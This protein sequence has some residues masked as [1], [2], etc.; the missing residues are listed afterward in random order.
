[1]NSLKRFYIALLLT[2]LSVAWRFA[3]FFTLD[4]E[5][6][7][8]KV[9]LGLMGLLFLGIG[10]HT[11]MRLRK[12]DSWFLFLYCW[13]MSWHWGGLPVIEEHNASMTLSLYLLGSIL[14]GPFLLSLAWTYAETHIERK[15][16]W[17]LL[18]VG[19]GVLL[20][21]LVQFT[22]LVEIFYIMEVAFTN[23]YA[24]WAYIYLIAQY[25]KERKISSSNQGLSLVVMGIIAGNVPYIL[26]TVVPGMDFGY[27]IEPYTI[28]FLLVP[29]TFSISMIRRDRTIQQTTA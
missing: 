20:F 18:P 21:G 15:L 14:I 23:V 12:E 26:A 27:G 11:Y 13:A 10:L 4:G 3:T 19:I 5:E 9:I 6:K 2:T 25:L 17:I 22:E 29:I 24:L 7:A 1:M 8:L 16:P 28:F